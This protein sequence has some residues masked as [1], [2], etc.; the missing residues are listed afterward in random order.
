MVSSTHPHPHPHPAPVAEPAAET[1]RL[2]A[3]KRQLRQALTSHAVVDQAIGVLTV[4]GRIEPY[5]GFTALREI[6][7]HTNIKL[8][9]VAEQILK[10]ARG[11]ALP[12]LLLRE[13][14]AALPATPPTRTPTDIRAGARSVVSTAAVAR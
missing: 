1:E 8:P 6:S 11:A 5:R 3:E 7:Q 10:H 4:R 9:V 13:L 2:R 14:H 12:G